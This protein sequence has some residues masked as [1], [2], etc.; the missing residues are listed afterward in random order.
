MGEW[1]VRVVRMQLGIY[2]YMDTFFGI[3][4]EASGDGP[5]QV[6]SRLRRLEHASPKG[7]SAPKKV[8]SYPTPFRLISIGALNTFSLGTLDPLGKRKC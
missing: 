7:P 5:S 8:A 1:A 2:S 6:V 4:L 3:V